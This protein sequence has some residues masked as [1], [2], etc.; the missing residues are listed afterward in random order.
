MKNF[1]KDLIIKFSLI[2]AFSI[3][4]GYLETTVAYYQ[5]IILNI[6]V[7]YDLKEVP[8]FTPTH[9]LIEQVREATTII[10]LFAFALLIGKTIKEK[11]AI[12]F[13]TFGI[14]DI[15]YYIF[16]YILLRWPPSLLTL[17]LLFLIPV[18]WVAAVWVPVSTSIFLIVFSSV[19]IFVESKKYSQK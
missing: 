1:E 4:M 11:F 10:M 14:W 2:L 16:Y 13:L 7:D 8:Y 18:P 5:R 19:V 9:L 3:A 15:F 12:F 17:D 6:P